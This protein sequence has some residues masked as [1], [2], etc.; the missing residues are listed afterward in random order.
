MKLP[1]LLAA[2]VLAN[3]LPAAAGDFSVVDPANCEVPG[4]IIV[5]GSDGS[6]ADRFGT[7][8][9]IVNDYNDLPM[10]GCPVDVSFAGCPYI[11]IC[12]T[13]LDP[14]VSVDCSRRQLTAVTNT[15]GIVKF[16]IIGAASPASCPSDAPGCVAVYACGV[17]I[18]N[19]SVAA[20]DLDG[21]P[22]LTGNDFGALL[23]GYFC[24][25]GSPRLDYNGDGLVT[26]GDV[27]MWLAEFFSGRSSTGCAA[28]CK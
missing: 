19:P 2:L 8:T 23:D 26:G 28:L 5:V 15:H 12:P 11:G 16:T 22:G 17:L 27:S 3:A 20:L 25:S 13:Q 7:F 6:S 9:V 14:A 4:H 1:L 21:V 18:G 10:V 24:G